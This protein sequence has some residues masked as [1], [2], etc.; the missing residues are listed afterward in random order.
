VDERLAY[1]GIGSNLD[2]P[3]KQV[4]GAIDALKRLPRSTFVRASRLYRTAPWGRADQPAFVNAAAMISTALSP[5][6]LLDALLAIER[7]HGRT[8]EGERWG[9]RVIDL[10][11]LVYADVKIDEPGL[12]VPHPHLAERA[13]ALLPLADLDPELEIPGQ[14]RIR[15]LIERADATGCTAFA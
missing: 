5:R 14:G 9:P 10:D 1:I 11:I 13:F 2:D 6:E 4:Y 7:V 8:R 3:A 12:H 15:A